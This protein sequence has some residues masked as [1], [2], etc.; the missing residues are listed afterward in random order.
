[1]S[2]IP[3]EIISE[4]AYRLF[5]KASTC[6]DWNRDYYLDMYVNIIKCSGWTDKDIDEETVRRVDL[7]WELVSV[8]KVIPIRMAKFK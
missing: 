4:E 6:P 7:Y 2:R 1:M 3:Y 8:G 5:D